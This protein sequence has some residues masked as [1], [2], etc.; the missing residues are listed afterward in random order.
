MYIRKS[1]RLTVC[2]YKIEEISINEKKLC[3]IYFLLWLFLKQNPICML[4][5]FLDIDLQNILKKIFFVGIKKIEEL[6]PRIT[7]LLQLVPFFNN[8]IFIV[9]KYGGA[10]NQTD[11]TPPN[12]LG[13][14]PNIN[15][16][17]SK[18]IGIGQIQHTYAF[19]G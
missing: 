9:W 8:N 6:K 12:F 4:Y 11:Q 14:K 19:F 2:I 1:Y 7:N 10:E 13:Q 15:I 3:W 17:G 18:K 16:L 5:K